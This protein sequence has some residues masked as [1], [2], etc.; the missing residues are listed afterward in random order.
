MF[1]IPKVFTLDERAL[2]NK[3]H[4]PNVG[5]HLRGFATWKLGRS[6]SMMLFLV[7]KNTI[8]NEIGGSGKLEEGP[9]RKKVALLNN[10]KL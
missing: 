4:A 7:L 8:K 10:R 2:F 9:K 1:T 3:S 6:I 5:Q